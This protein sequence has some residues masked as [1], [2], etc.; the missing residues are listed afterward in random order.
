MTFLPW[1]PVLWILAGLGGGL[2]AWWDTSLSSIRA[3]CLLRNTRLQ[4]IDEMRRDGLVEWAEFASKYW[5]D[6]S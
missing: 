2:Y 6:P 3:H 5:K 1:V 4:V